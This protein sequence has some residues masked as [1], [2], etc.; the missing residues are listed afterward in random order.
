MRKDETLY[1]AMVQKYMNGCCMYLAAALHHK[2]GYRLGMSTIFDSFSGKETVYHVWVNLPNKQCLDV[3][4]EQ[5]FE[6]ITAEV[7]RKYKMAGKRRLSP[8]EIEARYRNGTFNEKDFQY[9]IYRNVSLKKVERICK[10][11]LPPNRF[12]VME[13]LGV[14]LQFLSKNWR[15]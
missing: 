9:R 12:E 14:A 1:Q 8:D 5:S 11:K 10:R 13:G 2:F 6:K 15:K 4:G 7:K 3:T